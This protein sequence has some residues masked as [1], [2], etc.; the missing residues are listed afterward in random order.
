VKKLEHLTSSFSFSWR[1]PKLLSI[2]SSRATIL[3]S[4]ALRRALREK[5]SPSSKAS[6]SSSSS[7]PSR[8][9]GE[10]PIS[11]LA[12]SFGDSASWLKSRLWLKK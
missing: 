2:L 11:K 3:R 12:S 1:V 10:E 5:L 8:Q 6:S 4:S 7:A 9:Q